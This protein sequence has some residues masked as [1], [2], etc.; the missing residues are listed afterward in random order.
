MIDI[1]IGVVTSTTLLTF[2]GRKVYWIGY[3]RGAR[4]VLNDWKSYMNEEG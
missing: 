2:C 3:R 4:D 1:V